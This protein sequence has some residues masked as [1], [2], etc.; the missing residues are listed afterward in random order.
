MSF[1]ERLRQQREARGMTQA[2]LAAALGITKSAVGNYENGVSMPRETILLKLFS[3]L[4]VEPNF[5]FQDSFSKPASLLSPSEQHLI[6]RY[7]ALTAKGKQ[8]VSAL[9]DAVEEEHGS[10][11]IPLPQPKPARQIP[12]F[13]SPAAAGYA[14]PI[15]GEEYELIDAG[16]APE[17]AQFAVRIQGDSME[18]WL[19]DGGVAY[20]NH[21]PLR[22]GDAGIFCVD[23]EMFCK[24]YYRDPLGMVYLFSLNRARADADILLPPESGRSLVCLG[25][26]ML[27]TMPLPGKD[28]E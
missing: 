15:L 6:E 27:H 12:L 13:A 5:L 3:A 26:V 17:N 24:Q 20:V 21:D 4:Q 22:S 7:R 16:Q 2:D 9:L 8:A 19:R 14:T 25:R 1:Q 18:P 10:K 11:Q 28:G 23:G